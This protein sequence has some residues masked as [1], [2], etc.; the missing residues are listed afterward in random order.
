MFFFN[1][2][3]DVGRQRDAENPITGIA[4]GSAQKQTAPCG[5]VW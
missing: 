3:L 4:L 2:W 5:A 1:L